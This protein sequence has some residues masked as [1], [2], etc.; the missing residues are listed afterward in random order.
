MASYLN[1]TRCQQHDYTAT[2][3]LDIICLLINND[4]LL[5]THNPY[6]GLSMGH[7]YLSH[8]NP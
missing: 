3:A 4:D 2:K 8:S 1:H 7:D 5:Q 6:P